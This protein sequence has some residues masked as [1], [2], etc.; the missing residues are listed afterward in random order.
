MVGKIFFLSFLL[1]ASAWPAERIAI[2]KFGFSIQP[3]EETQQLEAKRSPTEIPNYCY[4]W[5]RVGA[6]QIQF[7][8]TPIRSKNLLEAFQK[9][10]K[11]LDAPQSP[12]IFQDAQTMKFRSGVLAMRVKYSLKSSDH[13]VV[14]FYLIND[15]D[16]LVFA[17]LL[18]PPKTSSR[19]AERLIIETLR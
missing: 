13:E 11:R 7:A 12:F 18:V 8:K 1:G 14:R 4:P 2:E 19:P 6:V 10:E 17:H 16:E 5:F 3:T 15:A 9:N